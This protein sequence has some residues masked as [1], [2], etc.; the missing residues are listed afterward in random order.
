MLSFLLGAFTGCLI[1]VVI[2]CML[3]ICRREDGQR[4]KAFCDS[5]GHI[6]TGSTREAHRHFLRYF[7]RGRP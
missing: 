5:R 7:T 4:H 2:M 1:G 3:T 6:L